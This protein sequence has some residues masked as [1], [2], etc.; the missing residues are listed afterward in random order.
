AQ[1]SVTMNNSR[2]R[3]GRMSGMAISRPRP[4]SQPPQLDRGRLSVPRQS[5]ADVDDQ[6]VVIG[7]KPG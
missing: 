2:G 6:T 1:S 3:W 7:K 5:R 4:P